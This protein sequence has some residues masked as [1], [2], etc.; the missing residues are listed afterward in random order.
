[1][2][3]VIS[4][5]GVV[6]DPSSV[7]VLLKAY[8]HRVLLSWGQDLPQAKSALWKLKMK[9]KEVMSF[10]HNLEMENMEAQENKQELKKE[11][12]FYR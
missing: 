1:M 7:R 6:Q 11:T 10:L 8:V 3:S 2:Q 5:V 4:M 12:H 9:E